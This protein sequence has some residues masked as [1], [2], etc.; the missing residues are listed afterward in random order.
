[1]G[2]GGVKRG[3]TQKG[4]GLRG[5]KRAFAARPETSRGERGRMKPIAQKHV[6]DEKG[7][8]RMTFGESAK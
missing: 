4:L 6:P 3:S 5:K 8:G 1:M 7:K 2:K